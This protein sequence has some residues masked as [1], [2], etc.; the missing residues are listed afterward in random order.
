[1]RR[2]AAALVPLLL[3]SAPASRPDTVDLRPRWQE[4]GLPVPQ[5]GGRGTCS[6]FVVTQALEFALAHGQRQ[7]TRLSAEFLNWASNDTLGQAVDGGFFSDLWRGFLAHGICPDTDLPY[8]AGFDP[9]LRPG[10]EALA[11]AR[12]AR[13]AGL[14]LC[15]I[16]EW[17]VTTGLTDAQLQAIQHTLAQG[18]PVLSGCRWP[19]QRAWRGDVLDQPPPEGVRDG[20][21]VLL[22]GYRRDPA[23]PG[24][25]AFLLRNSA[26]QPEVGWMTFAYARAYTNDAAWIAPAHPASRPGG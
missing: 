22:I 5:Q 6:V 12:A 10:A 20:H 13:D 11:N 21:S 25:G 3:Q 17:N 7:G 18:W 23:Q 19:R 8:R 1:M 24:G 14:Q 26:G 2:A 4:L 15:W 9:A 16:K